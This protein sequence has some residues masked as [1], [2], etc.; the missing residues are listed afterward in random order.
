MS[1]LVLYHLLGSRTCCV[2]LQQLL[3]QAQEAVAPNDG[4]GGS[5]LGVSSHWCTEEG[6]D[7][8]LKD[9]IIPPQANSQK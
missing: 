7:A 4:K 6:A 3:V 1:L 5:M 8:E 2:A 9:E